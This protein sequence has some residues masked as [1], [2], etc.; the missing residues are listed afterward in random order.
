MTTLFGIRDLLVHVIRLLKVQS[1]FVPQDDITDTDNEKINSQ[2][3]L[4]LE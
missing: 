2:I 1:K 4:P 3:D